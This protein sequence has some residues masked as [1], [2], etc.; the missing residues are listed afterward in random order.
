VRR[1]RSENPSAA[2]EM[3]A[4]TWG[5]DSADDRAAFVAALLVGLGPDDEGFLESALDDR[6]KQVRAAAAELLA[7]LPDSAFVRRMV[8][9][10]G[11]LLRLQLTRGKTKSAVVE[12]TL[13][14]EKFDPAWA[15]DAV[16]E[17]PQG[18]KGMRQGWLAQFVSAIPPTHWSQAWNLPAEACVAAAAGEFAELLLT[19]WNRAAERH[20][21]PQ[22]IAALLRTAALEGQGPL[23]LELLNHLP[24]EQQ[25]ALTVEI[26]QSPRTT[27][28]QLAELFRLIRFP[29]AAKAAGLLLVRL[30][31][32][33][34]PQ[35]GAYYL[36]GSILKEAAIRLPPEMYD[37]LVQRLGGTEL[38]ASRKAVDE[39]L[40]TLLIRR[41]LRRE[42][43][44]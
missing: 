26:L 43:E 36:V 12:V 37:E 16:A 18:G 34:D 38:D 44:S 35:S 15:R 41:D 2:R 21:D 5:E 27:L 11:P 28:A 1:V 30:E 3:I 23:S 24:A 42:F 8:E 6:S 17:K 32:P 29:L 19:A 25:Q 40:Q 31:A 9:R 39:M 4:S 14:P 33:A 20:P 10:A 22:W 7:R 13:P